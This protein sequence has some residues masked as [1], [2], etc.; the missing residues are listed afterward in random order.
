VSSFFLGPFFRCD[1]G[2]VGKYR[3]AQHRCNVNEVAIRIESVEF[4]RADDRV[5][6]RCPVAAAIFA[7]TKEEIIFPTDGDATQRAFSVVVVH[8]QKS[9]GCV[10]RYVDPANYP[11]KEEA[12]LPTDNASSIMHDSSKNVLERQM[13]EIMGRSKLKE[14]LPCDPYHI[15]PGTAAG[16]TGAGNKG[17]F[18]K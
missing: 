13:T 16:S 2:V 10:V 11:E 6:D 18:K 7:R 14:H 8:R 17:G 9:G 1:V 5:R 3:I 15:A 4:A 12:D